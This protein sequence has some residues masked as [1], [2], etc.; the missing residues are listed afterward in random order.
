MN[1]KKKT[2]DPSPSDL[3]VN[4]RGN[5]A[6][7]SRQGKLNKGPQFFRVMKKKREGRKAYFDHMVI[8][9]VFRL[10]S[11]RRNRKVPH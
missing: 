1:E 7:F 8:L 3:A 9:K 6:A 2:W 10:C 11:A 5:E 4:C